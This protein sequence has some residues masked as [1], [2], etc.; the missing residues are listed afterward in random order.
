[1]VI[2]KPPSKSWLQISFRRPLQ[3]W[4]NIKIQV[5]SKE[6]HFD[7]LVNHIFFYVSG[8]GKMLFEFYVG[9]KW[10]VRNVTDEEQREKI[11]F[12]CTFKSKNPF[13][14]P[15]KPLINDSLISV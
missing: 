9:P 10:H 13:M 1:M 6:V 2:G 4:L 14:T 3:F 15:R 11:I 5:M 8:P 7:C 12:I